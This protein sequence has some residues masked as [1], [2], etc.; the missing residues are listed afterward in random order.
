M[1]YKVTVAL[2]ISSVWNED[3]VVFSYSSP[4]CGCPVLWKSGIM[5]WTEHGLHH[6][7]TSG[8]SWF[9]C[10]LPC[11]PWQVSLGIKFLNFLGIKSEPQYSFSLMGLQG[12]NE[13]VHTEWPDS[14]CP[15]VDPLSASFYSTLVPVVHHMQTHFSWKIL[16]IVFFLSTG[17]LPRPDLGHLHPSV[18]LPP[19]SSLI[20][21]FCLNFCSTIAWFGT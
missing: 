2:K 5:W 19:S 3:K 9:S 20:L 17:Q 18:L 13:I 11:D 6:S 14:T 21:T 8:Q 15:T 7:W 1:C 16:Q 12:L 10:S 4:F